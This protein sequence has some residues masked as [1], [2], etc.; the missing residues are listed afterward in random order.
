MDRNVVRRGIPFLGKSHAH[1]NKASPGRWDNG[2]NCGPAGG[3]W[4]RTLLVR[5]NS[6][7]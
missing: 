6:Q 5:C 4:C 2:P 3:T 7:V 1:V